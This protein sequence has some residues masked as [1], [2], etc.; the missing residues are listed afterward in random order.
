MGLDTKLDQVWRWIEDPS[1][2]IIGIYRIGGVGKTT[3]LKKVNNKFLDRSHSFKPVMWILVSKDAE[4]ERVQELIRNE[5]NIPD[6]VWENQNVD[7]KAA[8]IFRV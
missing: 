8:E 5:L 2:G 4:V 6:R 1:V 7:G 3:L